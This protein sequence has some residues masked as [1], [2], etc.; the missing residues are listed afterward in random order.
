MFTLQSIT[1]E[2]FRGFPKRVDFDLDVPVVLAVGPNGTGKSSLVCAIEWCLFGEDVE[3]AAHTGIRERISW[4]SRNR[5]ASQ[6]LVEMELTDKGESLVVHRSTPKSGKP[7]FWF[8]AGSGAPVR[9][10][11]KLRALLGGLEI[12]DFFTAI[13]LH[14]ESLRGLLLAKPA[15]R[16]DDFYRLL[17][18]ASLLNQ[19]KAITDAKLEFLLQA[20]DDEFEKFEAGV[21][22]KVQGRLVDIQR[23][24]Q[25]CP[26][27]GLTEWDLSKEGVSKLWQGLASAVTKF[28]QA[29][30]IPE[31]GLS[32]TF[33]ELNAVQSA[34]RELQKLRASCPVLKD[35]GQVL[36]AINTLNG[37]RDSYRSAEKELVD[38]KREKQK[39]PLELRDLPRLTQQ[40][41]DLDKELSKK[42]DKR[43]EVDAKGAVLSEALQYFE[44]AGLKGRT[45]CPVCQREIES[46]E[47]IR[48][49][50]EKEIQKGILGPLQERIKQLQTELKQAKDARAALEEIEAEIGRKDKLV[51]D[52]RNKIARFLNRE[53]TARDDPVALL[54]GNLTELDQ[55]KEKLERQVEKVEESLA[56]IDAQIDGMAKVLELI[57]YQDDLATLSEIRKTEAY[58]GTEKARLEI[59]EFVRAVET[60][61]RSLTRTL[62]E[63]A[64][65]R[66]GAVRDTIAKTF[67]RLTGRSDFPHLAVSPETKFAAQVEGSAGVADALSVLNQADT[68]CAALSIFLALAVAPSTDHK[69]GFLILDDPNQ[70]LDTPHSERLVEIL[71]KVAESRQLLLST[72]DEGLCGGLQGRATKKKVVY[73]FAEWDAKRGPTIERA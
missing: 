35:R 7:D 45:K 32:V 9:E 60:L 46:V 53:L 63:E 47:E 24:R 56:G 8:R 5:A 71:S 17:G 52:Q 14:Q 68:N 1:I 19:T 40:I 57:R 72:I 67:E 39:L 42:K 13:H 33:P 50:Y 21:E 41:Q 26:N 20:V 51:S 66:L 6:C 44:S 69:L 61:S 73:R 29:Y 58:R 23:A 22:G 10:E 54:S 3:T 16:K 12:K 27:Q 37:L 65:K 11:G 43:A 15:E 55:K 59:E 62:E 64:E 38:A 34:K 2:G 70:S 25:E 18:L 4:A 48:N 31:C 30:S 28:C 49:H 36:V